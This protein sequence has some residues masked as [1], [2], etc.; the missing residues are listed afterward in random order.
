MNNGGS[1]DRGKT[2]F[3]SRPGAAVPPVTRP[4]VRAGEVGPDLSQIGGKFD[5][6]SPL[7]ESILDPSAEILQGYQSWVIRTT[8]ER[9]I[10]GI[11]KSESKTA[12]A[13]MDAEGKL[14]TVPVEDIESRLSQQSVAYAHGTRRKLDGGREFT[15]LIAYLESLRTGRRSNAGRRCNGA[16]DFCRPDFGPRW[17]PAG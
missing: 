1:A 7:I 16:A 9:T 4:T 2:L 10:T 12:V 11:I 5:R 13:L 15:D 14:V 17:S 8:S 3:A 6:T